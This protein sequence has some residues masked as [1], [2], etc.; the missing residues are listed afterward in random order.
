MKTPLAKIS[1]KEK[2]I[3]VT[4]SYKE[5]RANALSDRAK[6][7]GVSRQKLLEMLM[8]GFL[9]ARLRYRVSLQ[10]LLLTNEE[11]RL[12]EEKEGFEANA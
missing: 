7:M 5:G 6:A 2:L 11:I 3:T 12:S 8:D 4:F 1:D 10:L 9:D